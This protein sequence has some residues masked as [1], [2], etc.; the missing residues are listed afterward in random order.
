MKVAQMMSLS[1]NTPYEQL[2]RILSSQIERVRSNDFRGIE[3]VA[4]NCRNVI[5]QI[6]KTTEYKK[7]RD[8]YQAQRTRVLYRELNLML[9]A[10]KTKMTEQL[11]CMKKN[12][13][14]LKYYKQSG[15]FA[16]RASQMKGGRYG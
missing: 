3:E 14:V 2:Q 15:I 10:A 13:N 12:K 7:N 1:K 11:K 8:G 6:Q 16:E 9:H 5:E 4:V